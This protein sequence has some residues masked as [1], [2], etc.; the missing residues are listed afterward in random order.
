M[1]ATA[2][3]VKAYMSRCHAA[4]LVRSSLGSTELPLSRAAM[5]VMA[6]ASVVVARPGTQT[7]KRLCVAHQVGRSLTT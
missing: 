2:R 4:E 1:A 3:F 7:H 5:T 6:D